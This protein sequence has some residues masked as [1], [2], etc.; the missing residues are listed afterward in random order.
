MMTYINADE[1]IKR[2]AA[3]QGIDVLNLV[4]SVED[5]QQESEQAA[6]QQQSMAMMQAAPGLLK[7]PIADPSKNPNAEEVINNALGGSPQ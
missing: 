2:L 4:K 6:Q 5:R 1:A 7:A 3:A